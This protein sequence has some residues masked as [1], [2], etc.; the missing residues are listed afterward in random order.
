MGFGSVYSSIDVPLFE[1]CIALLLALIPHG[2]QGF[3]EEES[4]VS[5]QAMHKTFFGDFFGMIYC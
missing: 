1:D 4:P 5:L 3:P 2:M